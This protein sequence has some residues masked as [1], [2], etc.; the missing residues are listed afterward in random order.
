MGVTTTLKTITL[1]VS[2][3]SGTVWT[4]CTKCSITPLTTKS[5][6]NRG[7]KSAE[8]P[9]IAA[10]KILDEAFT[11]VTPSHHILFSL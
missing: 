4:M 7:A 6:K 11:Q 3:Q 10:M 5:N 9:D 1:R 8:T 2:N